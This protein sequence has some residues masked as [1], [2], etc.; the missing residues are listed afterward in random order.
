MSDTYSRALAEHGL[1]DVQPRYRKL[2]LTLKAQDAA[3]YEAAVARYRTDV[4]E[5]ARA[6]ADPLAEW[7]AYGA[8]LAAQIEPGDLVT[9]FENG[10]AENTAGP[11]P[12]GPMLIHLPSAP[13]RRGLLIAMPASPSEAQRETAALLCG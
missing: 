8:W 6:S 11:A 3:S 4:E 2:L 7:L 13:N 1:D 10:R 12:A 9:I 5:K